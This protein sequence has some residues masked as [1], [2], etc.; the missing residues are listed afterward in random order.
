MAYKKVQKKEYRENL[1]D[2]RGHE[3]VEDMDRIFDGKITLLE[4][5]KKYN[6]SKMRMSQIFSELYGKSFREVKA[7]GG[8][9]DKSGRFFEYDPNGTQKVTVIMSNE[10]YKKLKTHSDRKQ[11]PMSIIARDCIAGLFHGGGLDRVKRLF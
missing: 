5:G 8:V 7:D 10:L 4:I 1:L 6:L 2:K 3:F 11:V 9:V